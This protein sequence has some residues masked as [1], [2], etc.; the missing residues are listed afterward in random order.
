MKVASHRQSVKYVLL[1][2]RHRQFHHHCVQIRDAH[3]TNF[4]LRRRK[5]RK[6]LHNGRNNP[7][8]TP[9]PRH[10]FRRHHHCQCTCRCEVIVYFL[11]LLLHTQITHTN[12]NT[13]LYSI[14]VCMQWNWKKLA[15]QTYTKTHTRI[16]LL[17]CTV[18]HV[19]NIRQRNSHT[20]SSVDQ[21]NRTFLH[22]ATKILLCVHSNGSARINACTDALLREVSLL[23]R[24]K[25]PTKISIVWPQMEN[26]IHILYCKHILFCVLRVQEIECVH[27]VI[28]SDDACVFSATTYSICYWMRYCRVFLFNIRSTLNGEIKKIILVVVLSLARFRS[29]F[30][31]IFS[32]F[33]YLNPLALNSSKQTSTAALSHAFLVRFFFLSRLPF[34][35]CLSSKACCIQ[36]LVEE[37][38]CVASTRYIQIKI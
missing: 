22:L 23:L 11:A 8:A 30:V 36:F 5:P 17:A 26:F 31:N 14:H 32:C 29:S 34:C 13:R 15:S 4:S 21:A 18:V 19:T 16:R 12:M 1:S 25:S 38:L 20:V 33:F 7:P 6:W 27:F 9:P 24:P 2:T 37:A 35:G 28:V 10:S 3:C